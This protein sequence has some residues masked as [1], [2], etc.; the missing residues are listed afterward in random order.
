MFLQVVALTTG[1]SLM[2]R[3]SGREIHDPLIQRRIS[4]SKTRYA[5]QRVIAE[6]RYS[7][8]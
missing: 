7:V 5:T 6:R 8:A 2:R 1:R 4:G 3:R